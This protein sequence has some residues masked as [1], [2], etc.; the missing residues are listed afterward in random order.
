MHLL[1]IY[2]HCDH[3]TA[4]LVRKHRE[5]CLSVCDVLEMNFYFCELWLSLDQNDNVVVVVGALGMYASF[6]LFFFLLVIACSLACW[7][8]WNTIMMQFS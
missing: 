6:K 3:L 7:S 5:K 1:F 8:I 2:L 4:T